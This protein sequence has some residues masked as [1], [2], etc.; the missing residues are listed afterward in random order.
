[1][2]PAVPKPSPTCEMKPEPAHVAAIAVDARI[3][4]FW[5]DKPRVWF[6]RAE[7][8]LNPQKC[9]DEA[10]FQTLISK[11]GKEPIQLVTDLLLKP[12]EQNK[13]ETLKIR[14]LDIYEESETRKIQKL[15]GEMEL[16]D[17][18]P[19]QL[20]RRMCDLARDKIPLDT[21]RIL[22]QGHLPAPIR[23]VLAITETSD[24]EKLAAAA[25]K[26]METLNTPQVS[27]VEAKTSCP[28]S[29]DNAILAEIAKLSSRLGR[30]EQSRRSTSRQR[31]YG[32]RSRA[33]SRAR[34]QTRCT[35]GSP[36]WLCFYHFRF[37][38]RAHKCVQPC[39]WKKAEN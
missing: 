12:P 10:K 26:V 19:S 25:D 17:Q 4:E 8:V 1:M 37:K 9:S 35:P 16:G 3:P 6:I 20:L 32:Q 29:V 38:E 2:I 36:D 22:W 13:Y 28:K 15:I 39:S 33:S 18:R 24:V 27:E 30:M 23:T 21:V 34:S 14:L 31:R 5:T 7:A 11:L